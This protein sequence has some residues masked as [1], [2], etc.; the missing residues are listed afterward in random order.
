MKQGRVIWTKLV[1]ANLLVFFTVNLTQAQTWELQDCIDT[2]LVH[3]K[4][5]AISRNKV[6]IGEQRSKE[7]KANLIP[8]LTINGEYKYYTDLPYQLMPL[9]V[10]GGPEG[11]FKEAQFG[12]PHNINANLQL[13]V[14]LYNPQVYGAI[15]VTKIAS[16]LAE[17]QYQ[18]SEE[19]IYLEISNLYYNAQIV[20]TQLDFI[21]S[22]ISNNQR[23]LQNIKLAKEQLLANGTDVDRVALQREQLKSQRFRLENEYDQVL[24]GL[25]FLMGISI[26]RDIKINAAVQYESKSEYEP[27]LTLDL[28]M[29][30]TQN[31]LLKT[32]LSTLK[33]TR[34]PSVSLFGSYG[35]IG[36]GY[37]QKPNDFLNF[38]PVGLAG[39]QVKYPL[40]NGT[41]T[42]RKI[43]QKKIEITN[44]E[45]QLTLVDDQNE[46]FIENAQMDKKVAE[47][48]IGTN[49]LQVELAKSIY[50]NTELQRQNEVSSLN[51]VL[52]ADVAYRE[53]QQ[54]YLSA[55]VDYLKADLELKN[56]SGNIL[57]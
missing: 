22:N 48:L 19:Q 52:M 3:N 24:N 35:T 45:I 25:K 50:E 1:F 18:K 12:V 26:E 46:M 41:V 15:E 57:K 36:Y 20:Q 42:Q 49:M 32:E 51:D 4:R 43:D 53:A 40:F 56:R 23:L 5:L 17:I 44:S 31:H 16:E 11:Q 14:P 21:D 39:L 28:L 30:K 7:A 10:F 38:Y 2:A 29:V 33:R 27:Q 6:L 55:I 34:L 37:D 8:K 54:N 47:Q 13:A 9:S